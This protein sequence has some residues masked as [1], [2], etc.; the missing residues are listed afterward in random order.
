MPTCLVKSGH[1]NMFMSFTL[2]GSSDETSLLSMCLICRFVLREPVLN[3]C[4]WT[5]LWQLF[6]S[7]NTVVS[8]LNYTLKKVFIWNFFLCV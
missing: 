5:I 6:F 4:I 1:I 7:T 3:N 2:I 8:I